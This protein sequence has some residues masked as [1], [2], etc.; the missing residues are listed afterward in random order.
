ME[1]NNPTKAM[2]KEKSIPTGPATRLMQKGA[3]HPPME[4]TIGF[5]KTFGMRSKE[6][7]RLKIRAAGG[8][9]FADDLEMNEIKGIKKANP[10][11]TAMSNTGFTIFALL[12]SEDLMFHSADIA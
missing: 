7:M 2:S 6:I 12:S 11:G 4:T 3:W 10:K 5:S 1:I 9:Y 8:M